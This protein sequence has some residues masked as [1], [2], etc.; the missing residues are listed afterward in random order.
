[1]ILFSTSAIVI[2][3]AVKSA[4]LPAAATSARSEGK[5]C[6]QFTPAGLKHAQESVQ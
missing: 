2:T 1:M 5:R 4:Q 3:P 6:I